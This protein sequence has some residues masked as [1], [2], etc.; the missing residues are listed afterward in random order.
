MW[1]PKDIGDVLET[2]TLLVSKS[3]K[4][5]QRCQNVGSPE[6]SEFWGVENDKVTAGVNHQSSGV[7]ECRKIRVLD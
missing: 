4:S 5:G 7:L 3:T 6:T 1:I 2:V